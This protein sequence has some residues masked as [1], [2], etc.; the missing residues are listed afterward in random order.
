M[1]RRWLRREMKMAGR[2]RMLASLMPLWGPIL[3][4]AMVAVVL[5]I[6]FWLTGN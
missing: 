6:A 5:P 1:F 3:L 4:L 2:S